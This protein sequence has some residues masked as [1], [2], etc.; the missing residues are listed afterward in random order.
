MRI[1]RKTSEKFFPKNRVSALLL[2]VRITLKCT[3]Q[4]FVLGHYSTKSVNVVNIQEQ[5]NT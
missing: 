3:F 1:L 2:L 4:N 5:A